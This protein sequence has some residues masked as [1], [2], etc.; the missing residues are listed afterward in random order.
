M[1]FVFH[2]RSF[3]RLYSSIL[4]LGPNAHPILSI[5]SFQFFDAVKTF[6][7]NYLTQLI[8]TYSSCTWFFV[9][10]FLVSRHLCAKL[11]SHPCG[12]DELL[13]EVNCCEWLLNRS[14]K[15]IL[16]NFEN[17]TNAHS[18]CSENQQKPMQRSY[19]VHMQMSMCKTNRADIYTFNQFMGNP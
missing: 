19:A 17:I 1:A 16:C 8:T 14:I 2:S 4:W 15:A 12:M 10:C 9:R 11:N 13:S 6:S 18:I 5:S 7:N 3:F